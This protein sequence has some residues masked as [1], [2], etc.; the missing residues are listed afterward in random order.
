MGF[1]A[2]QGQSFDLH[3]SFFP[4]RLAGISQI[5]VP[6]GPRASFLVTQFSFCLGRGCTKL[7]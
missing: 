7:I 5:F 2:H 4:L 1:E 6:N 3:E